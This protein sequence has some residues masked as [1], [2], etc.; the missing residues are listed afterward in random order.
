LPFSLLLIHFFHTKNYLL[1]CENITRFLFFRLRKK[2][3]FAWEFRFLCWSHPSIHSWICFH[4]KVCI[5]FLYFF[6]IFWV[7][8]FFVVVLTFYGDENDIFMMNIDLTGKDIDGLCWKQKIW[9][10][11]SSEFCGSFLYG[12]FFISL[13]F[14]VYSSDPFIHCFE[15]MCN[16]L[17][18]LAF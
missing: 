15:S 5:Y 3:P 12:L 4:V 10:K 1:I 17:D 14:Y 8:E 2:Y 6:F 11:G 18:S 9:L 13:G 7:L 16:C